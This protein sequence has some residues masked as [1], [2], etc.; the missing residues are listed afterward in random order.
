MSNLAF[1]ADRV[2]DSAFIAP[3]AR[4]L[5][6][7]DVAEQASVW[8]GA[9]LRGDVEPIRIGRQTNIQDGAILHTDAGFPC[10]LG[11]RISVAHG[12]IVHG[13]VVG[14]D[15]LIGMGAVVLTGAKIGLQCL[16]GSGAVIP[17]HTEIPPRSVVLGVPGKIVRKLSEDDLARIRSAA[18]HYVE[19]ISQYREQFPPTR[20]G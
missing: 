8:F 3:G 1:Q 12:A 16:I 4:V 5:G 10:E 9:V 7:V 6:A 20:E 11:E 17:E 19:R 15:S 13:A 14:D 18:Q 2:A